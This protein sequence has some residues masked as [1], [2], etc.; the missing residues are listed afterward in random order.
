MP[1]QFVM[2]GVSSVGMYLP[3]PF[4]VYSTDRR[5][6]EVEILGRVYGTGTAALADLRQGD[7]VSVLGPLGRP[8]ETPPG[9]YRV[10]LAAGGIG[11]PP[12]GFF[13][14]TL[15]GDKTWAVYGATTAAQLYDAPRLKRAVKRLIV[16]TDDG[17]RGT[18]GTAVDGLR[19]LLDRPDVGD[20]V[21]YA[22]G[23]QP[24]LRAVAALAR[25]RGIGCFVSLEERMACGV[26]ACA[27]CAVRTTDGGYAKVCSDGPVFDA[28]EIAW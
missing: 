26:G 14:S 10:V 15:D 23:P 18:R 13:A 4:S 24:M 21:V 25:E 12:L 2:L 19:V 9:G 5:R 8:F 1:G 16:T 11:M 17:S 7:V 27:G 3:R 20:A 22:C 28:E 6:R